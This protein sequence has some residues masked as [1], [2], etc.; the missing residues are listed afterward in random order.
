MLGGGRGREG[1]LD[2]D[3]EEEE[4]ALTLPPPPFFLSPSSLSGATSGKTT[5]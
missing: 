1:S 2:D 3:N 5:A 4:L